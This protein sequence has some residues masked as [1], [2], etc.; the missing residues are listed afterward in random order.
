M[1]STDYPHWHYDTMEEALPP[2]G[3]PDTLVQK[4]MRDNAKAFYRF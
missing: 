4:I 2:A 1:F 3:L